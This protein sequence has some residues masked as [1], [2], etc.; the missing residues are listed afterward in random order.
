[1]G[2][3]SCMSQGG[4]TSVNRYVHLSLVLSRCIHSAMLTM[5]QSEQLLG[6]SATA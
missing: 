2:D 3:P 5:T 1:M 6:K 4:H